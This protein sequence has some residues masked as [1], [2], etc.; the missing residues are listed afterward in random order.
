MKKKKEIIV[1]DKTSEVPLKR[2]QKMM[3]ADEVEQ[4]DFN[5]IFTCLTGCEESD[6]YQIKSKDIERAANALVKALNDTKAPF[7][8]TVTIDGVKY[9]C[10][11]ELNNISF[12]MMADVKSMFSEVS[13]WHKAVAILYRPIIRESKSLGGIYAIE[14]HV[15]KSEAYLERQKVF[16]DGPAS[17]F[18]GLRAFFLRGSIALNRFIHSSMESQSKIKSKN[19]LHN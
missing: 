8:R 18:I 13:D 10:E 3:M 1:P 12:G 16:Q 2:Y 11:P 6:V 15:V 17:L 5:F 19:R 9:G 4:A 14:P 7:V